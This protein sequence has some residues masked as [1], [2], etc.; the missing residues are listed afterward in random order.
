MAKQDDRSEQIK[1]LEGYVV[2]HGH[3]KFDTAH[4]KVTTTKGPILV[5]IVSLKQKEGWMLKETTV[6]RIWQLTRWRVSNNDIKI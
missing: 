5:V 1:E 2:F 4:A 3:E 6:S